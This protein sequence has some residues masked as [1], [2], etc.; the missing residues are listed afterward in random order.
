MMKKIFT[1]NSLIKTFFLLIT[2]IFFQYF[3]LGFIWHSI[4]WGVVTFALL[5]WAFF[6]ISTPLIGRVGCGWFCFFGSASDL[7]SQKSLYKLK[8][9]KPKLWLRSLMLLMFFTSA[10][11]F[12][13]YNKR[14]GITHDFKIITNFLKLNFNKHYQLVWFIDISIALFFGF[15]AERRWACKNLCIVGSLS[16]VG[17]K[18]SRLLPVID[19]QKCT[20]C[21]ICENECLVRI[22]MIDEIIKNNG[23]IT[24]SE[25]ILCG[26]CIDVCPE[27][28]VKFKFVWN[29]NKFKEKSPEVI[30]DIRKRIALKKAKSKAKQVNINSKCSQCT[31][32]CK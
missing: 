11:F 24:N 2:P 27:N 31:S 3:A 32:I 12:Y 16:A 28:A 21:K 15:I 22:P 1:Y 17:A 18:Y 23:L 4:Y 29:R 25:C 19:T 30:P 14:Q 26:K 7:S 6:I 5:I 20:L 13:F 8:W 9:K 10:I